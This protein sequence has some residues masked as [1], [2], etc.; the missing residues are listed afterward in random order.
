MSSAPRDGTFVLAWSDLAQVYHVIAFDQRDPAGW[1]S[2]DGDYVVFDEAR[3]LT[4]WTS[5]P[6]QPSRRT[7]EHRRTPQRAPRVGTKIAL[8]LFLV[9]VGT[10]L[11]A[12][13]ENAFDLLP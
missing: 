13:A 8:L 10:T 11:G 2:Q 1:M 3:S 4:H 6:P 9:L 5:L 7:S 12:V